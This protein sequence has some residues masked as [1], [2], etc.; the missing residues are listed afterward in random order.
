[1]KMQCRAY[2]FLVERPKDNLKK[3]MSLKLKGGLKKKKKTDNQK[4]KKKQPK[5]KKKKK[6]KTQRNE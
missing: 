2:P 4:K 3:K 5:K 6:K 1:M